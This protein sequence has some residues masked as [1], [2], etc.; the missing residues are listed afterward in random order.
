[1]LSI[2]IDN[3]YTLI[4]AYTQSFEI[5]QT[6]EHCVLIG[7]IFVLLR[8]LLDK[9]MALSAG[10]QGGSVIHVHTPILSQI[11]FC[12]FYNDSYFFPYRWLTVFREFSIARQGHPVTHTCIHSFFSHYPAPSQVATQSSQCFFSFFSHI[13]DHRILGRVP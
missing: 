11:L 2:I 1:M 10:Q 8:R 4:Y 13:D 9:V 3:V 12:F 7:M 6:V 5:M